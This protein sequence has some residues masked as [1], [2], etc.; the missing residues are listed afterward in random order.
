[1][2]RQPRKMLRVR[3]RSGGVAALHLRHEDIEAIAAATAQA[4]A[5]RV[6][7]LIDDEWSGGRA[8]LARVLGVDREWVYEHSH[9]LGAIRLGNGLRPRLRFDVDR[10]VNSFRNVSAERRVAQLRDGAQ[11]PISSC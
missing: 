1:V 3:N 8:E 10:A 11:A 5:D 4:V 9:Q 2:T 7:E 6:L